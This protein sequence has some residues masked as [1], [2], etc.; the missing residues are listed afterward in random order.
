MALDLKPLRWDLPAVTVGDT[1]P[2][3]QF[4]YDGDGTL[5]RVRAKIKD[6]NGT[7]ALTLDSSTSGMSITTTTSGA[8]DFTMSEI[9]AATTATLTA[10]I[11]SYDLETTSSAGVRTL[12]SGTWE[13]LAQITD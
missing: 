3:T 11:Y 13:L 6:A 2:A 4:T 1:Y 7:T 9:T 8:W 12:L 5:T 10:G